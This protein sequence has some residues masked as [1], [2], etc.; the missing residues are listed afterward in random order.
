[1]QRSLVVGVCLDWTTHHP[2]PRPA[3]ARTVLPRPARPAVSARCAPASPCPFGRG[4]CGT[5]VAIRLPTPAAPRPHYTF[6]DISMCLDAYPSP[7]AT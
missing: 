2:L 6:C 5:R 1:M 4:H 3:A 7:I